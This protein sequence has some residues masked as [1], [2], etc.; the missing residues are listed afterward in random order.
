MPDRYRL[1]IDFLCQDHHKNND[2]FKY[3]CAQN[4]CMISFVD[5]YTHNSD[6]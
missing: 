6:F 4:N 1:G 5:K 3:G 2:G